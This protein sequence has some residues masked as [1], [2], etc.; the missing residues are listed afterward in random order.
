[1]NRHEGGGEAVIEYR[2]SNI[3]VIRPG[4]YVRCAITGEQ[5]LLDQLKYWSVARQE[6][7]VSPEAVLVSLGQP[8]PNAAAEK[9]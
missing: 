9:G 2:D 5:I 6:A 7:Y 8:V 3:R 1:M 4:R